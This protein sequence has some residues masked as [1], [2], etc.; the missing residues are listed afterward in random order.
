M[1]FPRAF[2]AILQRRIN[3]KLAVDTFLESYHIGALHHD[4]IGPLYYSN[5][6]TFDGFGT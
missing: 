1:K 6:S 2:A 3:W 5:R 4:T